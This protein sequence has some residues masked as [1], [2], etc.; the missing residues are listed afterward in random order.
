[1][2]N[3]CSPKL[4][5]KFMCNICDYGCRKESDYKKHLSTKKHKKNSSL[6]ANEQET[7][8]SI[9][10]MCKKC[11]KTY[12]GRNGLWYHEQKCG[13]YKP[14]TENTII[15]SSSNEIKVLTDLVLELVKINNDIQKQMIEIC[16]KNIAKDVVI[17]KS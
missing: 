7:L 3:I 2:E 16:K 8:T 5:E 6:N 10:F 9:L 14:E 11:N 17:D 12:K 13:I 4:A 15:D 1:M